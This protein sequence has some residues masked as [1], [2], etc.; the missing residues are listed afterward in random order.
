MKNY[1]FVLF[2]FI[3]CF[4]TFSQENEKQVVFPVVKTDKEW[5]EQL[6]GMEYYV[7]RRSGTEYAFSSALNDE[8]RKGVYRCAGCDAPL[9]RSQD[10]Y[11]SGSGWPSFDR[12]LSE[13]AIFYSVDYEIGVARTE[14]R[15][16]N[17]GS[18]LGHVFED[19]PRET[20]G[21]RHCINGVALKFVPDEK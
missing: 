10:K 4:F 6:N 5:K 1:Y 20:T 14:E 13:K 11:D 15:C 19:G 7:L 12:P 17:C 3:G 18:H 21:L 8:K 9:F 16:A 2:L